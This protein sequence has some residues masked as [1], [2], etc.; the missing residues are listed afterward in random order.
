M[1]CLT[2]ISRSTY[3]LGMQDDNKSFLFARGGASRTRHVRDTRDLTYVKGYLLLA[4]TLLLFVV[5]LYL[6]AVSKLMPDTGNG[7]LDFIKKVRTSSHCA[8]DRR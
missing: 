2:L 6:V 7:I 3:L 1:P 5:G 8:R 4:S